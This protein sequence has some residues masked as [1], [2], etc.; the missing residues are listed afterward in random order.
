M[1]DEEASRYLTVT[2]LQRAGYDV[3][4]A[5]NGMQAMELLVSE[6]PPIVVTDWTMPEM[7]GIALCK[8]I[9]SHE[10]IPFTYIVIMAAEERNQDQVIQALDAGADDFVSKPIHE[11]ELLARLGSG[12]RFMRLQRALDRK[13]RDVHR[14]NA[15]MTIAYEQLGQANEKLKEIATTDELT[16]LT[17]R[18]A[19]IEMLEEQWAAAR[20]Y[21]WPL[22]VIVFDIDYFKSFND[23][24]GH[25]I[26]DLVLRD[27]ADISRRNARRE[28]RCCRIGG[29]EFLILCPNATEE[30]AAGGAE[31]IR[32]AVSGQVVA[33][34]GLKL[35]VSISLGVAQM[36][37]L[38]AKPDDLLQAADTALYAAKDAGRNQVCCA[39]ERENTAEKTDHALDPL[40]GRPVT[41][42]PNEPIENSHVLVV[43]DDEAARN[44]IRCMLE[45][46]GYGVSEA[47]D[48]F[49][50][51]TVAA[52]INPDVILM[53]VAMPRMGGVEAVQRLK[54]NPQTANIPVIMN[55]ARTDAADSRGFLEAGAEEF[56]TKP[57]NP[58][59]LAIR[60]RTM[61]RLRRE[62]TCSNEM[63]GEQSRVLGL[64]LEFSHRVADSQTMDSLLDSTVSALRELTCCRHV[65]I[66][67]SEHGSKR[68]SVAKS[69]WEP[70]D[71]R[72]PG[73][74]LFNPA[75][76]AQ[77]MRTGNRVLNHR[78]AESDPVDFPAGDSPLSSDDP[79]ICAALQASE[80]RV[81]VVWI[82]D[83]QRRIPFTA[84]ELEYIDLI[85]NIAASAINDFLTRRARDDARDSIVT[86]LAKLAESR[87][88]DTGKHLDRVTRYCVTLAN[89][90][91]A[92]GC[93]GSVID[94]RFLY[95]LERAVPLHDIGKVAVPDRILSKPGPLRPDEQ[96]IMRT[97]AAIGAAT[98]R[99][100]LARAPGADFLV[101]AEKIAYGH[102]EWFNGQGYP[103]GLVGEEIALAARIVAVADVYDALTTKRVYKDAMPHDQAVRIIRA[104]RG[105]QFDPLIVAAFEHCA[106]EFHGLSTELAD[107]SSP[108]DPRQ[109]RLSHQIPVA[110]ISG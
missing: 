45:S 98:I 32:Q 91:R 68:L 25:A 35:N 65:H 37:P 64:L 27:V 97:H 9:R 49:E 2:C 30:R 26:G 63:R 78:S 90:L 74:D 51:L 18:R 24:Y 105:T 5:S 23:A 104:G 67:L 1:D 103:R 86:A 62:L 89:Q 50:A 7:D 93:F 20:R 11:R 94:D 92:Q 106:V 17:N 70:D 54:S 100:V 77:V 84:L 10:G 21:D 3:L 53:D 19:A 76:E 34:Q 38:M 96:D 57:V 39:S 75:I 41:S 66:L 6:G 16:G 87:D 79:L 15:E 101:M 29:E 82:T 109:S 13:N 47:G 48:G 107:D 95:E 110:T 108:Q 4:T 99:S 52:R 55:C 14:S 72:A 12:E 33:H 56:L 61:I 42:R 40:R 85:A 83:A 36:S 31:R 46:L 58:R 28:E 60:V 44:L 69:T 102:H 8:A 22:S 43:D 80:H 71:A 81:G 88:L 59:E 73:A